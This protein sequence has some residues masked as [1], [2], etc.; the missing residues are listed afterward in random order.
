MKDKIRPY[1]IDFAR[2]LML[3]LG[4]RLLLEYF[5]GQGFDAFRLIK[6]QLPPAA[7]LAALLAALRL[8]ARPA[9]KD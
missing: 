7:L 6:S 5:A 2:I 9:A 8:F 4:F 1:L 3:Y